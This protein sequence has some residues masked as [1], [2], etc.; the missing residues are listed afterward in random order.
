MKRKKNGAPPW[1]TVLS[2][3]LL[4]MTNYS[5][6][7]LCRDAAREEAALAR[8][9]AS[10]SAPAVVLLDASGGRGRFDQLLAEERPVILQFIF[11]SCTTICGVMASTLAAANDELGKL[12]G[13]YLALSVTIDPEYD[14]PERLK[15]FSEYFPSNPHWRLLTGRLADIQSVLKAF[16]AQ[17]DGALKMNHQAYTFL[18]AAPGRPWLRI[19]GLMS[20]PQLIAEYK[21][22]LD[23]AND[24]R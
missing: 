8:A 5:E 21:K 6:S 3:L 4:C 9:F 14:T 18:R 20:A 24:P 16:D 1:R 19:E 22:L 15:E 12:N 2:A 7:A 10:Y 11:T 13:D 23:H 17:F